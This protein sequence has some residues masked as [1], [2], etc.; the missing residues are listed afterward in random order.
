MILHGTTFAGC[1]SSS[2]SSSN[3]M[4]TLHK[5]VDLLKVKYFFLFAGL[6]TCP[7]PALTFCWS[8][9]R[10]WALPDVRTSEIRK[11]TCWW[12]SCQHGVAVSPL[13]TVSRNPNQNKWRCTGGLEDERPNT[14]SRLVWFT[15]YENLLLRLTLKHL[16]HVVIYVRIDILLIYIF[17]IPSW[18]EM[19]KD[20]SRWLESCCRTKRVSGIKAQLLPARFLSGK[21]F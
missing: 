21:S 4:C 14:P 17:F 13:G 2:P 5:N 18:A 20:W 11:Q 8:L 15:V 12:I 1:L 3:M 16:K 19:Y 6:L 10:N 7:V 9:H